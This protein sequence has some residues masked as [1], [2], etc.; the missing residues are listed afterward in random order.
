MGT[1][2]LIYR[3]LRDKVCYLKKETL[4]MKKLICVLLLLSGCGSQVVSMPDN[5]LEVTIRLRQACQGFLQNDSEIDTLILL[6]ED[7]R[8]QGLTKS[9]TLAGVS[10]S[11]DVGDPE[12][13]T[14]CVDCTVAIVDQVF[15]P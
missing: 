1:L 6:T 4:T 8:L 12:I 14:V 15:G 2:S 9:E 13:S 10:D 5:R 11:C 7:V 3:E